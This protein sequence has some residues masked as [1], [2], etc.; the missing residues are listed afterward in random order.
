M[1]MPFGLSNAPAAFQR[2]IN[3]IMTKYLDICCI[4]YLEDVL[5]YSKTMR[6]HT[7]DVRNVLEAIRD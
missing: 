6:D 5:V 3:R 1:V 4:V 2:W 7:R